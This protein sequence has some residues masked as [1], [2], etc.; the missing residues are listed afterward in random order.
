MVVLALAEDELE[1][2]HILEVPLYSADVEL[3]GI[4]S[5]LEVIL[6]ERVVGLP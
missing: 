6:S 1:E 3:P 5:A 2:D 4:G